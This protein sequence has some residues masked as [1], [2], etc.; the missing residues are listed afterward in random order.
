MKFDHPH[1]L[2]KDEAK[3]RIERLADYWK[4]RY[5]VAV[6]WT[7]DSGRLVGAVKG[8]TFDATLTVRE[9]LVEAEGTDP[10]LLMRAVTT[11]Y[12]KKKLALYLDPSVR[13]ETIVE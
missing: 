4:T 1:T 7:G 2:G 3:K 10:G 12:L 11:A 13:P 6:T 5:G 9:T 8:I